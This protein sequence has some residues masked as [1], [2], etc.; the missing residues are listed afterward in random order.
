LTTELASRAIGV[1]RQACSSSRQK[2]RGH[3]GIVM[4]LCALFLKDEP[5]DWMEGFSVG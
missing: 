5:L 1:A 2:K 4:Q 3:N